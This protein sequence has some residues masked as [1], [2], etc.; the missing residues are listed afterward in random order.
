MAR[1][2]GAPPLFRETRLGEALQA[3][4]ARMVADQNITA[5]Q[6]RA[7]LQSFDH[8]ASRELLSGGA[9][10]AAA[11]EEPPSLKGKLVGYQNVDEEWQW[12]V[13]DAQ[14]TLSGGEALDAGSVEVKAR[15]RPPEDA[16]AQA[17]ARR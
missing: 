1:D 8:A 5:K 2:K 14:L 3:A 11:A 12:V 7:I 15:K 17:R 6:A 10:A 13:G 9:A 4:V 16:A